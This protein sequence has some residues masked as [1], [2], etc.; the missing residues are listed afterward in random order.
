[1]GSGTLK[2]TVAAALLPCTRQRRRV[3][4]GHSN[5][6]VVSNQGRI[7]GGLWGALAPQVTKGA[8]KKEKGKKGKI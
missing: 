7:L 3:Y 2:V 5:P 8:P 4:S 6:A 1:M